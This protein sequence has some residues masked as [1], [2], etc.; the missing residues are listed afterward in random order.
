M[1]ADKKEATIFCPSYYDEA[2]EMKKPV[3][4][5][6]ICCFG[7]LAC[8]TISRGLIPYLQVK[9][10]LNTVPADQLVVGK[11]SI[12][13]IELKSNIE[14]IEGFIESQKAPVSLRYITTLHQQKKSDLSVGFPGETG[15]RKFVDTET[16]EIKLFDLVMPAFSRFGLKKLTFVGAVA[17]RQDWEDEGNITRTIEISY[18]PE[19]L[20]EL[21]RIFIRNRWSVEGKSFRFFGN[22]VRWK[23]EVP[24][25]NTHIQKTAS[26]LSRWWSETVRFIED[27]INPDVIIKQGDKDTASSIAIT[28]SEEIVSCEIRVPLNASDLPEEAVLLF[29]AHE[30]GH[31]LGIALGPLGSSEHPSDDS[32]MGRG[33]NA[34]LRCHPYQQRAAYLVYTH[35]AGTK[36]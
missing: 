25:L 20:D 5:L 26:I 15:I 36:F 33:R 23:N 11:G 14:N 35:P 1:I 3:L 10:P 16:E 22:T 27:P 17:G 12:L 8:E 13:T 30:F 7:F 29:L 28:D 34:S 19:R 4:I 21:A 6:A 18:E 31:C 9:W 2:A 32:F 24:G